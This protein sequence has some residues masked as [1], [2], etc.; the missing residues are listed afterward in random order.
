MMTEATMT[1]RRRPSPLDKLAIK[2]RQTKLQRQCHA[3]VP[4]LESH[5]DD[6]DGVNGL[7]KKKKKKGK[8]TTIGVEAAF[9]VRSP[10]NN[11]GVIYRDTSG[12]A[13]QQPCLNVLKSL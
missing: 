1:L 6:V 7:S 12:C 2:L 11:E 10:E 3:K 8:T 13:R 4:C 5:Y 9:A